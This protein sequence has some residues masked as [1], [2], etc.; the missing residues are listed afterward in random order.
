[1]EQVLDRQLQIQIIGVSEITART[2]TGLDRDGC[3]NK[4]LTDPITD[5][6]DDQG[7]LVYPAGSYEPSS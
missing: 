5:L 6:V 7:E 2:T 1:V 3:R 4:L